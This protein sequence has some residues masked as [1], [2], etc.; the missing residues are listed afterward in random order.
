MPGDP[1]HYAYGNRNNRQLV[2]TYGFTLSKENPCASSE[3]RIDLSTNPKEVLT[4]AKVL[5]PDSKIYNDY[6]NIDNIT[7]MAIIRS[8]KVSDDLLCYLR[9]VLM[10]SN[11]E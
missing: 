8:N 2:E 10:T 9:S 11:Y 6:E 4:S 3:F 1:V 7:E 5:L